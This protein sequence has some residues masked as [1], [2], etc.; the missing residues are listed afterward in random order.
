M[1]PGDAGGF[2]LAPFGIIS[3]PIAGIFWYDFS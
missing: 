1:A 2:V 3:I